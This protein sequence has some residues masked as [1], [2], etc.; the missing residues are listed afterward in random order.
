MPILSKSSSSSLPPLTPSLG[1]LT[2]M[3]TT[4]MTTTTISNSEKNHTSNTSAVSTSN[5]EKTA[6]VKAIPPKGPVFL[7]RKTGEY[8]PTY[9]EYLERM[10]LY[11][12]EE[13]TCRLTGCSGL[14]WQKALE[15]EK[16]SLTLLSLTFP[17]SLIPFC[18]KIIHFSLKSIELLSVEIQ[19]E[20][21]S[22]SISSSCTSDQQQQHQQPID[23]IPPKTTIKKFIRY[24]S[25]RYGQSGS[26][27]IVNE[28]LVKRYSIPIPSSTPP[29]LVEEVESLMKERQL[30]QKALVE[31]ANF[32]PSKGTAAAAADSI[33]KTSKT[34]K[35]P[36][37]SLR[38][39]TPDALLPER[40]REFPPPALLLEKNKEKLLQIHHFLKTNTSPLPI[41]YDHHGHFALTTQKKGISCT[42]PSLPSHLS[43]EGSLL[44]WLTNTTIEEI[45]NVHLASITDFT[46][47]T[48]AILGDLL[49]E[50][51]S[52]DS[53]N[54]AD[55]SP[56]SALYGGSVGSG[57]SDFGDSAA[58]A[59]T[60]KTTIN[61]PSTN[62][63][64]GQKPKTAKELLEFIFWSLKVFIDE[65]S[66]NIDNDA[67]AN[68]GKG[69]IYTEC[70]LLKELISFDSLTTTTTSSSSSTSTTSS[71]VTDEQ[72]LTLI[73]LMENCWFSSK[74]EERMVAG[75]DV[76]ND[77]IGER[78][79]SAIE[80]L[81]EQRAIIREIEAGRKRDQKKLR[82]DEEVLQEM[83][84]AAEEDAQV[85]D[86]GSSNTTNIVLSSKKRISTS[87]IEEE[88]K[89]KRILIREIREGKE[90]LKMAK[91]E[92]QRF[93]RILKEHSH[94]RIGLS[95]E[96]RTGKLFLCISGSLLTISTGG[97]D[98]DGGD[99][100]IFEG[101]EVIRSIVECLS[102][103]GEKEG[104]LRKNL[105]E[106]W[107][108]ED[109]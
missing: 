87:E 59:T 31:V 58:I 10:A 35:V 12:R 54:E 105:I 2:T 109:L 29:A 16:D 64:V 83:L 47:L 40:E 60:A 81:Q 62:Y 107:G 56:A 89:K 84:R 55:L 23:Q 97:G 18:L 32:D 52:V 50:E 8:F 69:F 4:T 17:I 73:L 33:A 96:D 20:L 92:Y 72:M 53:F 82:R 95:G 45:F 28:D 9:Q 44:H 85:V 57:D 86:G 74:E 42:K 91:K 36:K 38:F 34:P 37:L 80:F 88:R 25:R 65:N 101:E 104:R 24:S 63:S 100:S 1:G 13:W 106:E 15:S 108:F 11:E 49:L 7:I 78:I 48:P 99:I 6:T 3:T 68:V 39:P 79:A 5:D 30:K 103:F 70:P 71:K 26:P 27:W 93:T 51:K 75:D 22:L 98:D 94:I 77:K 76:G 19:K 102:P 61:I 43:P 41:A 46:S 14:T 66:F 67:D 90:L 21:K